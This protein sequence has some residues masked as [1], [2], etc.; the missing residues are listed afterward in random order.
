[1][2]SIMKRELGLVKL[3]V[4]SIDD[5]SSPVGGMVKILACLHHTDG[6]CEGFMGTDTSVEEVVKVTQEEFT[7]I[8]E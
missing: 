1:M 8:N 4:L 5:K 7:W 3:A 2:K 6:I